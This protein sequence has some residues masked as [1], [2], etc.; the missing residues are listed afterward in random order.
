MMKHKVLAITLVMNLSVLAILFSSGYAIAATYNF[1]ETITVGTSGSPINRNEDDY[2][3]NYLDEEDTLSNQNKSHYGS[4]TDDTYVAPDVT[5][6]S[7]YVDD[8][9]YFRW[10]EYFNLPYN[11]ETTEQFPDADIAVGDWA[12]SPD[13]ATLYDNVDDTV[14][15]TYI[16]ATGTTN[17]CRFTH[18]NVPY[19][20]D[21]WDSAI[22]GSLYVSIW[23]QRAST[24]TNALTGG[25]RIGTTD[26]TGWASQGLASSWTLYECEFALNPSNSSVW[27]FTT[28]NALQTWFRMSDN[29]PVGRIFGIWIGVEVSWEV[30]WDTENS[31][32]YI[33]NRLET[34][35]NYFS[36]TYP[37][38]VGFRINFRGN[39]S[40][41][42]VYVW[43]WNETASTWNY[44][45]QITS[46]TEAFYTFTFSLDSL[47]IWDDTFY[48]L[49]IKFT[50][51][52]LD[53]TQDTC[54]LDYLQFEYIQNSF[55]F[56]GEFES[57]GISS[58]ADF[59][60]K[61]KAYTIA[62]ES[63]T[64]SLYNFTSDAWDSDVITISATS[65]WWLNYSVPS[66][67]IETGVMTTQ[68][69]DYGNSNDTVQ[70]CLALDL[71]VLIGNDVENE[72]PYFTSTAPTTGTNN[73]A[74][75]Y[76]A[77]AYDA[78]SA[79]LTFD[80]EGNITGWATIVPSTGVISG[81]PTTV[82]YFYMNISVDDGTNPLVWQNTTVTISEEPEEPPPTEGISTN[83]V[84]IFV[85]ICMFLAI[86]MIFG[87]GVFD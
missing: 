76:D 20:V 51:S 15:T 30:N 23:A 84:V 48:L 32:Y 58:T 27:D 66:D 73:T 6:T 83:Q 77:N 9:V 19:S 64:V 40:G 62:S 8:N 12:D 44:E 47:E 39:H 31:A 61:I 45:L 16:Y 36:T 65:W 70:S 59:I 43:S 38:L 26:Y 13:D 55:S 68:I 53:D 4:E 52:D 24:G 25:I 34:K 75:S 86:I 67:Y 42:N 18:G 33:F 69:T 79:T 35:T 22:L 71:Y 85:L 81:T 72:A 28:V 80:L 46:T 1:S 60:L 50:F 41:D 54:W 57:T 37:N 14:D 17:P 21:T 49:R 56:D 5:S 63:W 78:E 87:L 3:V 10:S 29:V 11:N 2:N 82:G 74:F 7:L